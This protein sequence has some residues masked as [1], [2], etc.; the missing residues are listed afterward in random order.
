MTYLLDTLTYTESKVLAL[1]EQGLSNHEIAATMM[2]TVG[3]VKSHLH[4]SFEKLDARN[5][6]HAIEQVRVRGDSQAQVDSLGAS[7]TQLSIDAGADPRTYIA[8]A[9]RGH[10][11]A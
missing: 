6:L 5:R 4:R 10:A 8:Q 2:I 7:K 9:A 1:V 11:D 3:T